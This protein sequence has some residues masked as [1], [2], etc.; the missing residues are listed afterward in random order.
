MP[1]NN[2]VIGA[3]VHAPS[4]LSL[5]RAASRGRSGRLYRYYVSASIQRG[6]KQ[7]AELHRV[8]ASSIEQL[9]VNTLERLLPG[10]DT[11]SALHSVHLRPDAIDLVVPANLARAT[12]ARI[13]GHEQIVQR[14]Q[15]CVITIPISL[16]IRGG[17]RSIT[18]GEPDAAA[19]L[20]RTSIDLNWLAPMV[21]HDATLITAAGLTRR[22]EDGD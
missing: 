17:R 19:A 22:S 15:H 5:G 21:R 9:V 12:A 3:A 16:P 10:K 1:P 11:D 4:T 20:R 18:K 14:G 6:S 13:E 2:V 8:A 7:N